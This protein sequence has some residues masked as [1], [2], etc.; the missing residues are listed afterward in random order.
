[1][2]EGVAVL[3]IFASETFGVI[4]ASD[5]GA[6]LGAFG[7][8]REHMSLQIFE[9]ASTVWVGTPPFLF[10]LVIIPSTAGGGAMARDPG[11]CRRIRGS[12]VVN[13]GVLNGWWGG[14]WWGGSG[15][16]LGWVVGPLRLGM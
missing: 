15:L 2:G 9:D 6:L 3:V 12:S 11:M 16:H 10:V 8:V 5:D 4:F 1:M 13:R 7:L 14:G